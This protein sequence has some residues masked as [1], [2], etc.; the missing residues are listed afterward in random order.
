M[1]PVRRWLGILA[2]GLCPCCASTKE[3]ALFLSTE[4]LLLENSAMEPTNRIGAA[5]L[6]VDRFTIAPYSQFQLFFL[7]GETKGDVPWQLG[8]QYS[9]L[10]ALGN[11][12]A[13]GCCDLDNEDAQLGLKSQFRWNR[14]WGASVAYEH[15]VGH[16]GADGDYTTHRDAVRDALRFGGTHHWS[17]GTAAE[18]AARVFLRDTPEDR[19]LSLQASLVKSFRDM[20]LEV[21]AQAG[22]GDSKFEL[23]RAKLSYWTR[24]A[25]PVRLVPYVTAHYGEPFFAARQEDDSF[26]LAVGIEVPIS[27]SSE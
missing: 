19:A 27:M 1:R 5:V 13:S 20:R 9:M 22:S 4:S 10:L 15:L 25:A 21:G 17:E 2:V 23:A 24:E 12:S 11:E 14:T 7:R 3:K 18:V 16:R 6:P 26:E 8:V